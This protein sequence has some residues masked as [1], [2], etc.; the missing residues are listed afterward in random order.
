MPQ[1]LSVNE[2]TKATSISRPTVSRKIKSGEI[3]FTRI[4]TRVLIPA[5]F[6]KELEGKAIQSVKPREGA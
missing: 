1:F 5:S 4:G 2:F 3:P 6:L